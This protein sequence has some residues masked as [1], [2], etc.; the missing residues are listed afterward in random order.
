MVAAMM[1]IMMKM[2]GCLWGGSAEVV[3][4]PVI[5]V[6]MVVDVFVVDLYHVKMLLLLLMM[7]MM[8]FF[9]TK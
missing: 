4:T 9:I 6:S 1:V 7:M 2:I 8:L 3:S 5:L